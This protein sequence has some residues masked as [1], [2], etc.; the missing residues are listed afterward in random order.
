M[1]P[2][3]AAPLTLGALMPPSGTNPVVLRRVE[4]VIALF[5]PMLDLL[6]A[7]GDRVSRVLEPDDPYYA[8]ARMRR[9][10]ESAPRGVTF[11]EAER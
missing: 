4:R 10:G 5:A 8:P 11:E 1:T 7:V 9:A 6:L 3:V 2:M